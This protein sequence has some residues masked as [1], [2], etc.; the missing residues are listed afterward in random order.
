MT[1]KRR[2]GRWM[3]DVCLAD[4]TRIRRVSPV[5][6]R[7]GALAF[8]AEVR[9]GIE[10]QQA[11]L[12]APPTT[13]PAVPSGVPTLAEFAPE[14]LSVYAAVNNKPSEVV[15]KEHVLRN[16]LV[17]FFGKMRLDAIDGRTIERYKASRLKG[18]GCRKPLKAKTVNNHLVILRKLLAIAEE[19]GV[20]DKVVK[21]RRLP[22]GEQEFDWLKRPESKRFL[23]AVDK[24]YPQ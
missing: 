5:Q 18:I 9:A 16:H 10:A 4:G 20:I 23:A 6:T 8:E 21:I 19:W 12:M 7:A 14:F 3:I 22:V 13:V 1:V 11:A 15:S 2:N 17:P 24:Y